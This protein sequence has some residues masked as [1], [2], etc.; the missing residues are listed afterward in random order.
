MSDKI[1][2]PNH[3]TQYGVEVIDL[4]RYL[5]FCLGNIVKYVLRAPYKNGEEDLDKALK[6]TEFAKHGPQTVFMHPENICHFTRNAHRFLTSC[7]LV[8][9][10]MRD[11]ICA[12]VEH[13]VAGELHSAYFYDRLASIILKMKEGY[14]DTRREDKE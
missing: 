10:A 14:N 9:V 7:D 5:D 12:I 3:Y 6:Y 8:T 11:L 4:T 1:D 13:A 2:H